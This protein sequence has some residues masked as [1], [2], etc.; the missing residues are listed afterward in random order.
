MISAAANTPRLRLRLDFLCSFE[1]IDVVVFQLCGEMTGEYQV[2]WNC[3][4]YF[5]L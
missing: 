5:G 3:L 4:E 2:F 1:L